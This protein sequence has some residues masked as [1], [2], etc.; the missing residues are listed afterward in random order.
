MPV[1]RRRI[2]AEVEPEI[3]L[4]G[5]RT[6]VGNQM[7]GAEILIF[8][9]AVADEQQVV[10]RKSPGHPVC[11]SEPDR[12]PGA[13]LANAIGPSRSRSRYYEPSAFADHASAKNILGPP[14]AVV[15][16]YSKPHCPAMARCFDRR[17]RTIGGEQRQ[18]H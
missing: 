15:P 5:R 16:F 11:K 1:A 3:G 7:V 13:P 9:P 6:M 10:T 8:M 17:T 14:C 12:N 2:G 18:R 4:G